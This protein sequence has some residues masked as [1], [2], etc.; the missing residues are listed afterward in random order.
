VA[1]GLYYQQKYGKDLHGVYVFGADSKSARDSSFA[2]LGGLRDIGGTDKGIKSDGDFNV[3]GRDPQ[4]A[5]TPF[6]QQM[7]TSGSNYGQCTGA[8]T[9]TIN[10]RKEA[11]LQGVTAKVWD[12]GVSC[13]TD[14]LLSAGGSDV[15]G[16]YVDTLFL[17]FYNK[18]DLKANP[19][20]ANY[21]KYTGQD[22][23][24]SFGLY[25]WA[26]GVAFR[27]AVNAQ[28]KAGGVNS[29]T[30]KTIFEQLNKVHKFDAEGIMAPI[31]LAG[32]G[33]SNCSV[34]NQVKNGQFVRVNPTKAG[35]FECPKNGV[36]VRKLD[37]LN[38]S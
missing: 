18:A 22:K 14:Q 33:L 15:E 11:A 13:Y 17:P 31:D 16:E 32:R 37:L 1:R 38:N 21:V 3:S 12:C 27:D 5:Y 34:T 28:V 10:L 8:Y 35:T 2:S 29:V 20:L 19:M 30:R 4:S 7:K 6:V 26:A 36:V 9:C 23:I 24:A 25:A